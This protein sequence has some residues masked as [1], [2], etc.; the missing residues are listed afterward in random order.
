MT[1]AEFRARYPEFASTTVYPDVIVQDW[2]DTA[3]TFLVPERWGTSLN[4]GIGLFTAHFLALGRQSALSGANGAAPGVSSGVVASKSLGGA[5]ISYESIQGSF[6]N[7]GAWALTT[8][9][10]QYWTLF[11]MIGMGG[12]QL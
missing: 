8:Y 11:R 1:L 12:L 2:L 6:N 4:L 9:G 10:R 5:S 3:D 7:A